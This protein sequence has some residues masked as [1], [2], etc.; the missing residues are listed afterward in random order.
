MIDPHKPL[1]DELIEAYLDDTL[2]AAQ[3]AAV[4]EALRADPERQRQV[5]LQGRIDASL[6]RLFVAKAPADHRVAAMLES[7]TGPARRTPLKLVRYAGAAA[8]TLAAAAALGWLFVAQPLSRS[9]SSNPY[10]AARPVVD[11][12]RDAEANGFEPTYQCEEA[13]RFADTFERR[14]GVPLKL[15]KLPVGMRMLGLSYPGGLSADTTAMLCLIDGQRVMVFVDRL[16]ADRTSASDSTIKKLHV[17]RHERDGL[18]FY[19]VTPLDR[20]RAIDY[21][22]P[23]SN[24]GASELPGP[25]A[26]A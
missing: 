24:P 1:S 8:A 16:S 3:R 12:Y 6:Q 15:L 18:V 14:Q 20:P 26:A 21:L 5:E 13:D 19:E 17:F 4:E 9:R 7:A 23:L 25:K 2:D 22:A 11:L 10:F